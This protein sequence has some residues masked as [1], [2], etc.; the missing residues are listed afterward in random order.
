MWFSELNTIKF[1]DTNQGSDT[2]TAKLKKDRL[3]RIPY[4]TAISIQSELDFKTSIIELC[5]I[6]GNRLPNQNFSIYRDCRRIMNTNKYH[7]I[8]K[9][10]KRQIN[11]RN[12]K[13]RFKISRGGNFYYSKLFY[14]CSEFQNNK[15]V[16]TGRGVAFDGTIL[17]DYTYRES[18]SFYH[19]C[20]FSIFQKQVEDTSVLYNDNNGTVK[21]LRANIN[22]YEKCYFGNK[23]YL[24]EWQAIAL[25]AC[26]RFTDV[27]VL[28]WTDEKK[29][30]V[31]PHYTK[32]VRVFKTVKLECSGDLELGYI[33]NINTNSTVY[34]NFNVHYDTYSSIIN[35]ED[36][37]LTGR[38]ISQDI[39]SLG[40]IPVPISFLTD[41]SKKVKYKNKVIDFSRLPALAAVDLNKLDKIPD[42]FL[43]EKESKEFYIEGYTPFKE[44]GDN[45]F[46][47]VEF[48]DGSILAGE[49]KIGKNFHLLS[50]DMLIL[51]Q[52]EIDGLLNQN[53]FLAKP[54]TVKNT[55]FTT[56]FQN[57]RNLRRVENCKLIGTFQDCEIINCEATSSLATLSFSN[58]SII[59]SFNT[60]TVTIGARADFREIKNSFNRISI[61][62]SASVPML[63]TTIED[64]FLQSIFSKPTT[65]TISN[66]TY[67]NYRK[68]GSLT[69]STE[70]NIRI[71]SPSFKNVFWSERKT[72]NFN[73]QIADMASAPTIVINIKNGKQF[74]SYKFCN[75]DGYTKPTTV[76]IS[77][78]TDFYPSPNS[79]V[80]ITNLTIKFSDFIRIF[81]IGNLFHT[82]TCLYISDDVDIPQS[83][84][85]SYIA[86][87][88]IDVTEIITTKRIIDILEPLY[89]DIIYKE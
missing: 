6:F 47:N 19:Y 27:Y 75:F 58:C 63:A 45:T 60:T 44:V 11:P 74:D 77:Y 26:L 37:D 89:T 46:D 86:T 48:W 43:N 66:G 51:S 18:Y 59:N 35:Y 53:I 80:N 50:K 36:L 69:I 5:D 54:A 32:V 82:I 3:V 34:G 14:L 76:M 21:N 24:P 42:N 16:T 65:L 4:N 22:V 38:N 8:L 61:I 9:I 17:S 68:T 71:G 79:F 1:K 57:R 25:K 12:A 33:S 62:N 13:V 31:R 52:P 55:I 15:I 20:D 81:S 87:N 39:P 85:I 72:L 56:D 30:I 28:F 29:T 78:L 10:K 7:T 84:M 23:Y 2:N 49:V 40:Y 67:D 64:S 41:I 70:N 88:L 83:N 73:N